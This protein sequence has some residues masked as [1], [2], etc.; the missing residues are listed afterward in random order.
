MNDDVKLSKEKWEKLHESQNLGLNRDYKNDPTVLSY[1]KFLDRYRKHFKS[2]TFLDLGCG[3]AFTSAIL[4]K[5]GA[6][7]LGVDI[8]ANAVRQSRNLFKKENLKGSFMQA[9]LLN[10]PLS[11]NSIQFIYSC[12]SLEYVRDTQAAIK[13]AC[14]VLKPGGIMLAIFPVISLT[15]LTY[16][17]LRGDIPNIP[18][19]KQIFEFIHIKVFKGK[20]MHYGYEQSFTL[21]V[22]RKLFESSKFK[23]NKIDYFDTYY[24]IEFVPLL[25]RKFVQRLL[26]YRL[27]WPLVY[28]EVQK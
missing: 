3:I 10:L 15:T 26:K 9:D 8:S 16:H 1:K 12:M 27:F 11:D 17:Q 13:E 2:G 28:V 18:I 7:I 21:G 14:R 23:V 5:E 24:P 20:Y 19:L 6:S 22:L 4:A 25:M